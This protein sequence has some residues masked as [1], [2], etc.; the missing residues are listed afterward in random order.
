MDRIDRRRKF[1]RPRNTPTPVNH[2]NGHGK[3][4][5]HSRGRGEGG[6]VIEGSDT[7]QV[8]EDK[9]IGIDNDEKTQDR[10]AYKQDEESTAMVEETT[11]LTKNKT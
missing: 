7:E 10:N 1:S 3:Y 2:E 9:R 5:T 8:R 11:L 4:S 6:G